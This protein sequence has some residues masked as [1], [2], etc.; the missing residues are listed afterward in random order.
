MNH[1]LLA[2]GFELRGKVLRLLLAGTYL[3]CYIKSPRIGE[4]RHFILTRLGIPGALSLYTEA[5][6][7][8]VYIRVAAAY[9]H[10]KSHR[11]KHII[12][13]AARLK[14]P[15]SIVTGITQLILLMCAVSSYAE[16]YRQLIS[17][18][19]ADALHHLHIHPCGIWSKHRLGKLLVAVPPLDLIEVFRLCRLTGIAHL[20]QC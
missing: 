6:H 14:P 10:R 11:I 15:Q 16:R 4:V 1:S 5:I 12:N 18:L 7:R 8:I 3:I 20:T 13:I 9:L 2:L 17:G 19:R